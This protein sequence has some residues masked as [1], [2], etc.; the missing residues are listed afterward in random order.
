MLVIHPQNIY[1][2]SDNDNIAFVM[3]HQPVLFDC[4]ILGDQETNSVYQDQSYNNIEQIIKDHNIDV[5]HVYMED[6]LHWT[7][8]PYPNT[9]V[10]EFFL[11]S[12]KLFLEH[13]GTAEYS[14]K[15]ACFIMMYKRRE[16]RLLVS[17]WFNQ[18]K[19]INFDYTQGWEIEDAD[20]RK[21]KE[22]LRFTGY[23][24]TGFLNKKF[25]RNKHK[26]D[27]NEDTRNV[28]NWN[29]VFK[30]R[31]ASSTFSIITE[32]TFWEKGC[33]I[34][35]KY[36]MTVYG[37][38]F[39]I[40]CGGYGLADKL[41]TVGLDVFNDVIDHSYQYEIHPTLRVIKALELNRKILEDHSVK[42]LD[43]MDRHL[44]NLCLLREN[45]KSF[46]SLFSDSVERLSPASE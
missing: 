40:F 39:P 17:S 32:P 19:H 21:V 4:E 7:D 33:M 9:C 6:Y 38:C 16:N 11:Q 36:L 20:F 10:P 43:Y 5:E 44:N 26:N 13:A 35:E 27:S 37:C 31:F 42:K 34:T 2:T 22:Y 23:S 29:N 3:D 8:F 24:F 15:Q 30:E 41:T 12:C 1:K 25:I 46:K 45:L 18:N 28:S 14:D